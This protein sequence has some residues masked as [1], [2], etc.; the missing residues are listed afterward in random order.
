MT[1]QRFM[2]NW[3][4]TDCGGTGYVYP[5]EVPCRACLNA[6]KEYQRLRRAETAEVAPRRVVLAYGMQSST[7]DH[8]WHTCPD[9]LTCGG[10]CEACDYRQ[11]VD[12]AS[13]YGQGV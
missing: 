2:E 7:I 11:T 6:S 8:N 12:A 9:C 3:H 10:V 4:C 1:A 5:G 13:I